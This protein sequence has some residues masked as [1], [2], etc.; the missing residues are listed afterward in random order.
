ML[1]RSLCIVRFQMVLVCL[2]S[3]FRCFIKD[4]FW[5]FSEFIYKYFFKTNGSLFLYSLGHYK[6]D[7]WFLEKNALK[8]CSF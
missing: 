4:N 7:C 6:T 3:Y 8:D 2:Q 1:C 5:G